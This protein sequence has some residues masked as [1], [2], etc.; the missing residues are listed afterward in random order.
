MERRVTSHTEEEEMNQ[1]RRL[2]GMA[3]KGDERA[4]SKLFELYQ[5]KVYTGE[6]LKKSKTSFSKDPQPLN[7]EKQ[8]SAK[9]KKSQTT[10]SKKAVADR[11]KASDSA[12]RKSAQPKAA[13]K[14]QTKTKATASKTLSSKAKKPV[15]KP[16]PQKIEKAKAK[17]PAK[18]GGKVKKAKAP[19]KAKK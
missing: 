10:K 9:S 15:A 2:L 18:G 8:S 11:Q 5:V 4:I 1:R 7:S 14:A 6:T 16:K 19:V 3:R 12:P 17:G 13:K